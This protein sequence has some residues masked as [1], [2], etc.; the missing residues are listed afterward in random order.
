MK[1]ATVP[2]NLAEAIYHV[3]HESVDPPK[4]LADRVGLRVGYLLDAANPDRDEVQFQARWIVPLT[5]VTGNDAIVAQL[6][7]AVGGV[8]YRVATHGRPDEHTA[9]SL[10]EF[11]DYLHTVAVA[12]AD[13]SYTTTEATDCER[14]GL[15][16]VA[17]VLAHIDYVRARAGMPARG[18][19]VLPEERR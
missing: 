17:A 19:T 1:R 7:H 13:S 3:V 6:A 9:K 8:F 14:E 15:E 16:V 4:A 2:A 10:K 12:S 11:G 18:T 5:L